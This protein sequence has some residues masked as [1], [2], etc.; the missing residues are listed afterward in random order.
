[1]K[2]TK[3]SKI[4]SSTITSRVGM[5]TVVGEIAMMTLN[6]IS[7]TTR[8]DEEISAIRSKYESAIALIDQSIGEQTE[9]AHV[10]SLLNPSEFGD[11]KSIEFV[12]GVAGFRTGQPKLKMLPGWTSEMVLLA[13]DKLQPGFMRITTEV[14]KQ[15]IIAQRENLGAENLAK[16][17]LKV[18]QDES[19]YIDPTLTE[20]ETRSVSETS[21]AA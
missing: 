17:G 3:R 6:K 7:L 20:V 14:D 21:K 9:D 2:K 16:L 10:W 11:K 15:A 4:K 5:E 18:V 1:M 8:M 19:F 12:Q 13:V